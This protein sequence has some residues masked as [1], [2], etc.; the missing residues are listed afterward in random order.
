M[1]IV[2][3]KWRGKR[4]TAPKTLPTR[5]TTDFAKES[6][7][8]ILNNRFFFEDLRVLDLFAGTGNITYE[9]ASRGSEEFTCVDQNKE[10]IRFIAKTAEQL[11]VEVQT[12]QA[13]ALA[14]VRRNATNYDIVFA[15][16]PYDWEGHEEL[17]RAILEKGLLREGGE[18]IIEHSAST[19]LSHLPGFFEHRKYGHVHFSFFVRPEDLDEE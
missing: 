15:D 9:F 16:P 4:I 10:C 17:A 2:S 18:A 13:D 14:F 6:L 19:D 12:V 3:G 7:F 1:R 11:G 8:N 5:P